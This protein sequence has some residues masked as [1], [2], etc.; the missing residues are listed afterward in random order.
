MDIIGSNIK[1]ETKT[2]TKKINMGLCFRYETENNIVAEETGKLENV[3]TDLEALRAKGFFK[4]T[5]PDNVVYSIAYKADENGF[6][7]EGKHI[8]TEPPLPEA[9]VKAIEDLRKAGAI[10]EKSR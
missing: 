7:A 9:I 10:L 4:Y 1:I 6:V 3:G 5:G 2:I 8:P